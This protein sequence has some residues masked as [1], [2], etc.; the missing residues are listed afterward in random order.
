MKSYWVYI[1]SNKSRR[2][3]TG[4]TDNIARRVFEHKEKIFPD[5]F[6][7]RYNFDVLVFFE[8]YSR[9][10]SAK[11]REK[12]IKGWRKQKKLKLI[13]AQNPDWADLSLEWQ[14]DRGWKLE[15]EARSR[16]SLKR[17]TFQ[18]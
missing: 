12:E 17:K 7:A 15:P 8:R 2:L 11:V 3:Y 6:T 14:E 13:L 16:P 10:I 9:F 1:I 4:F 5:S 18:N